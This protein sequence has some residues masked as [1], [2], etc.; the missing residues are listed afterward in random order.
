MAEATLADS[1]TYG[2][3]LPD[4]S[5]GRLADGHW[6][7]NMPTLGS[8]NIAA[9]TGNPAHLKINEWLASAQSV[10]ANDF[11]ELYN[12]D[13]LPVDLTGLWLTDNPINQPGK[14]RITPLSYIP[15]Q[16]FAVFEA[17]GNPAQSA[18]HLNF[19]LAADQGMIG[20]FDAN[21]SPIDIVLYGP[22]Q[23][24][25]SQGRS[26]SGADTWS[27]FSHPT[28]GSANPG[29]TFNVSTVEIPLISMTNVWNYNQS[30]DLLTAWRQPGF[31]DT[32]WP[33]GAALFYVENSSLPAPKNTPLVIGKMTYYFRTHLN[34]TNNLADAILNIYTIV[35]DGAVIYLNNH[36]NDA[37][38]CQH[39]QRP[40]DLQHHSA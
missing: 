37:H 34:L 21:A 35:D 13:S 7:L 32:S 3:Q 19:K 6:G 29:K 11:I 4:M 14:H 24:D 39:G 18:R 17:D 10:F 38:L 1:I 15:A 9:A 31:D 36:T 26:P 2:L 23:T 33:S 28:P 30:G 5:I 40:G 25:V 12:P 8:A 20:L 16:G 27:F 22:Q